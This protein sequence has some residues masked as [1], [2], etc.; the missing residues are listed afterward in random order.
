MICPKY[1]FNF[2]IGSLMK[3]RLNCYDE[4][5]EIHGNLDA[6]I[7]RD[8]LDQT[9]VKVLKEMRGLSHMILYD[10]THDHFMAIASLAALRSKDPHT[11]VSNDIV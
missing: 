9:C 1:F 10:K 11:P 5:M 3:L 7:Q 6:R 8:G 2:H 4:F